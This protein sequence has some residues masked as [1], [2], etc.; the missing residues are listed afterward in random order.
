MGRLSIELPERQH[1]QI[2]A[3]AALHGLSIKDY[4]LERTLVPMS[5][6]SHDDAALDELK[7]FLAPRIKAARQGKTSKLS[8]E[9]IISK[10][11]SQRDI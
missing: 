7:G 6:K 4:I 3:L 8:I 9:K 2:K 1:K 11:K 10:A 5:G